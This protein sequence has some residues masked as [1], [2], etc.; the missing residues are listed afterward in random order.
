VLNGMDQ[1]VQ[2]NDLVQVRVLDDDRS[3]AFPSRVDDIEYGGLVLDW[4]MDNAARVPV[5]VDQPLALYFAREDAAYTFPAR[6]L[7]V[8]YQPSPKLVVRPTGPVQRIQ[9]REFYRVRASVPVQLNSIGVE[10]GGS[11][12][13]VRW[14]KHILTHTVDISGA[15]I[16]VNQG[17]VLPVGSEFEAKLNLERGQTTLKLKCRVVHCEPAEDDSGRTIY[18]IALGFDDISEAQRRIIVRHV[19][20]VQ[21]TSAKG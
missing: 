4:P 3:P 7:E 11:G 16:S 21:R 6:T 8:R 18:H 5:R 13:A 20:S 14:P 1:A 17:F 19:F 15:G 2:V 10:D 9:R 12:V